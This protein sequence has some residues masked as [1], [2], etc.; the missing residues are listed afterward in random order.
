MEIK[1]TIV[2]VIIGVLSIIISLTVTQLFLKKEKLSSEKDEKINLSYGILFSTWIISFSLLNFKSI[3]ILNEFIT[4]IIRIKT[5]DFNMQIFKTSV[6][7]IGILN[8]WL[9]LCFYTVEVLSTLY[10]GKRKNNNEIIN[11][12]YSYFII[13]G[14]LNLSLIY[15]LMPIFELFLK[16]F[17]PI[18]T[19]FYR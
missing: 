2:L 11:N 5:V 1:K 3:S 4:I 8:F 19:P 14:L 18:E 13:K 6:L 15:C 17:F 12:N 16:A 9:I 10:L 7:F